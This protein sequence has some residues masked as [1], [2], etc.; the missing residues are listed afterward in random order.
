MAEKRESVKV[1]N[2]ALDETPQGEIILRGVVAADSLKLLKVD[3]YQREVLSNKKVMEL[4]EALRVGSVPAITLGMRGESFR[5][6]DGNWYLDDDVYIVDG[7]QRVTG[8][9]QL[10][11]EDSGVE[12]HI[13]VEIHFGTTQQ[14]EREMFSKLNISQ[15]KLSSNVTL[16]NARHEYPVMN[17]LYR[18]TTEKAFVMNGRVCWNQSMKR[19]DLISAVTFI[20]VIAMLH[21]HAGPGRGNNTSEIPKGLEKI[22]DNVGRNI[23]ADNVRTFFDI[24]DQ[25]WGVQRVAYREGA[26]YMRSNFLMQLARVFSDHPI[27]W[28]EDRLCVNRSEIKK[29]SAFPTSDPE[30]ARLASSSGS[31]AIELLY[32]VMVKHINSGKRTRRLVARRSANDIPIEETDGNDH[33]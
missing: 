12:P 28:D 7:L 24:V 3:D 29:L 8:G 31:A 15:S 21:S 26:A 20:K 2:A 23:F 10:L 25:C 27:F 18:L 13:G 32:M 19:D 14:S 16:R 11:A 1:I 6:R 9:L 17:T 30:I 4:K 22:V 5:E 33:E